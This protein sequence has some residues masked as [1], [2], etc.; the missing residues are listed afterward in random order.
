VCDASLSSHSPSLREDSRARRQPWPAAW[1]SLCFAPGSSLPGFPW[2]LTGWRLGV[3]PPYAL[4]GRVL[5]M[6][7][8]PNTASSLTSWST[9]ARSAVPA[10]AGR[11]DHEHVIRLG[12]DCAVLIRHMGD[13]GTVP[14][15]ARSGP[16][17][18][19]GSKRC[20]PRRL[21]AS[22]FCARRAHDERQYRDID[23]DGRSTQVAEGGGVG[24][25]RSGPGSHVMG[26][27]GPCLMV[28]IP[29]CDRALLTP[30]S[31]ARRLV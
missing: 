11:R 16:P 8:V 7:L 9:S 17:R 18:E 19:R 12:V 21:E 29:I 10:A 24:G 26:S 5:G 14:W 13:A 25:R 4:P 31:A 22:P 3:L 20:W 23:A 30:G 15:A 1:A 27:V 28:F 2:R 6:A